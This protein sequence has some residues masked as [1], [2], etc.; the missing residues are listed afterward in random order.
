L[1]ARTRASEI[2]SSVTATTIWLA[3]LAVQARQA[4]QPRRGVV[5]DYTFQFLEEEIAVAVQYKVPYVLAMIN[6]AYASLI[7]QPE[8]HQYEMDFGVSF[9]Y[10]GPEGGPVEG[11]EGPMGV[12]F[13]A[14]RRPN[15]A[16]GALG[17][18]VTKP[19]DINAA[20]RWA[21][22]ASEE[23][24][25][26]ALVEVIVERETDATMGTSIDAIN[27]FEPVEDR[28]SEPSSSIPERD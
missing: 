6:N 21:V 14:L 15:G 8:K 27:E 26:P 13:V 11:P 5:G 20:L 23:K 9:A 3:A 12:D 1:E 2:P 17:R 18:R 16:M 22:E 19:E 24:R 25:V 4:R 28:A 10:E 7:R